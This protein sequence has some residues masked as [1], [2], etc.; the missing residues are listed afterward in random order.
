MPS[1]PIPP[2]G[3]CTHELG[4]EAWSLESNSELLG[5]VAG[6]A[7]MLLVEVKGPRY[8]D[9]LVLNQHESV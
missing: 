3:Q 5:G 9:M 8:R 7:M 4:P 6:M 1:K 2:C